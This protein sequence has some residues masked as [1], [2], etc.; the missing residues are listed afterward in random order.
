M[1][2]LL[3][4]DHNAAQSFKTSNSTSVHTEVHYVQKV[5][6]WVTWYPRGC[7]ENGTPKL[8]EPPKLQLFELCSKKSLLLHFPACL[9]FLELN[10]N[11]SQHKP[12]PLHSY[13]LNHSV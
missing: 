7:R 11:L 4:R 13:H 9:D 10:S 8:G 1:E 3:G 5:A 2:K 12:F 6:S